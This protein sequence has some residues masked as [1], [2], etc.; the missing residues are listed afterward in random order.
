[1]VVVGVLVVN[2]GGLLKLEMESEVEGRRSSRDWI[3][4]LHGQHSSIR[5]NISLTFDFEQGGDAWGDCHDQISA[6]LG[7]YEE[8]FRTPRNSIAMRHTIGGISQLNQLP[9]RCLA[10]A[11][12]IAS[13][14]SSNA[15]ASPVRMPMHGCTS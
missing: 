14:A 6:V 2:R 4:R 8:M 1:M 9:Y 3:L 15:P 11:L 7:Q 5:V 12:T 10:L 13:M